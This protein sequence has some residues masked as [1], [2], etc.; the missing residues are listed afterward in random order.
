MNHIAVAEYDPEQNAVKEDRIMDIANEDQVI[1]IVR[2]NNNIPL[3]AWST[4][5]DGTPYCWLTN[6]AYRDEYTKIKED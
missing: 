3:C 6:K 4:F 5:A 1:A 2:C